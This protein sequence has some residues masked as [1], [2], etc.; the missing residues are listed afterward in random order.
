[1]K[2][3]G[4]NMN[5]GKKYEEM[6]EEEMDNFSRS[7]KNNNKKQKNVDEFINCNFCGASL[8]STNLTRHIEKVHS[9]VQKG[10]KEKNGHGIE[11]QRLDEKKIRGNKDLS[12]VESR[13]H[14]VEMSSEKKTTIVNVVIL[15][16]VVFAIILAASVSGLLGDES[17]NETQNRKINDNTPIDQT[18][19]NENPNNDN[20][21]DEIKIPISDVDDGEIHYYT[22]EGTKFYVQKNPKGNIRTR[23]SICEPCD[24]TTF[25]LKDNGDIID[26][27]VC[28]TQWDSDTYEGLSGG[29]TDYPPP[30]LTNEIIGEDIIIKKSDLKKS[31]NEED[32]EKED[33]E[34]ED[35]E[36]EDDEKEDEDEIIIP[37]S[38][39][40]D[41]EIHYYEEEGTKFYVHKNPKGNFKTRISLCEPC[42]GDTFTLKDKGNTIDCDVC[43]TQW[44]SETYEGKSGGCQDYPPEHLDHEIR[45]EDIVIKKSDLKE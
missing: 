44:D 38:D 18:P 42:D 21:E 30:Y 9:T 43:H 16:L 45:G 34:K 40:D 33:D 14:K 1:M 26:C 4:E 13:K 29:C 25:T 32:D 10:K 31:T 37:I 35:D 17:S 5:N 8:K 2:I 6:F 7:D 23:K 28:G 22:E 12:N 3:R 19:N 41:G 15:I 36:K 24:G 39:V 20:P 27:D 11:K